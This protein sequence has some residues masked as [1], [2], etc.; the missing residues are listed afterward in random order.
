MG[1]STTAGTN[2]THNSNF[3]SFQNYFSNL[4]KPSIIKK[5]EKTNQNHIQIKR[6]SFINEDTNNQEMEENIKNNG[7]I[8]IKE[9]EKEFPQNNLNLEKKVNFI[10][11]NEKNNKF[12]QI[13][14]NKIQKNEKEMK[15]KKG[16]LFIKKNEGINLSSTK[17][18]RSSGENFLNKIKKLPEQNNEEINN[19]KEEEVLKD[20]LKRS[21]EIPNKTNL[22]FLKNN[23]DKVLIKGTFFKSNDR[24]L[25]I[26]NNKQIENNS[27]KFCEKSSES[28]LNSST[29]FSANFLDKIKK[30]N[31]NPKNPSNFSN[32]ES[33]L[34]ILKKKQTKN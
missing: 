33:H 29:N 15:E 28:S 20:N 34:E 3:G 22:N 18:L 26:E 27:F 30:T 23:N 1:R 4:N 21:I 11:N 5:D 19:K 8:N 17:N 2:S 31:K 12:A 24:N 9:E 6:L 10:K 32:F 14:Q 25:K 16:N 13:L 7:K